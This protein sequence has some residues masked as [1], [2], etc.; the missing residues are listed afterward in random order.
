VTQL[1]FLCSTKVPEQ[2]HRRV[3]INPNR[4]LREDNG[5]LVYLDLSRQ[6]LEGIFLEFPHMLVPRKFLHLFHLDPSVQ[7]AD[8]EYSELYEL[9]VAVQM[10]K[11][12][13]F[14]K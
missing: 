12:N 11:S 6:T 14:Y 8:P 2:R 9:C 13:L 3:A 7:F 5:I 4:I 10:S 1:K